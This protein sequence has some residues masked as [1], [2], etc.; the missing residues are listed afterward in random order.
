M[1][2]LDRPRMAVFVLLAVSTYLRPGALL[3]VRG[4]ELIPPAQGVT[5]HWSVLA[6]P[7][8]R[9]GRSKIGDSD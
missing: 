6:H 3:T 7:H 9:P 1:C 5:R 2:H 4:T 8:E